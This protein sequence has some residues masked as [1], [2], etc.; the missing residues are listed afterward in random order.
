MINLF[1][2]F[3][4][5]SADLLRSQYIAKLKIPTV[6]MYDDGFLPKEVDSPIQYFC[7]FS[8]NHQ[9]LYFDKLPLPKYWRIMSTASKGEVFDLAQK[10]ADIIYSSGNNTRLI[11]EVHWLA[12]A[13]TISWVDHYNRH[14]ERFARTYY[15]QGE[16][17]QRKYYN[18]E[19][20]VVI[21]WNLQTN[22]LFLTTSHLQRHF[23]SL[24][25]FTVYY[26]RLRHYS[27]DHV[28]YNTLNQALAVSL[29]LPNNGE[30]VLFWHEKIDDKL[31]GNMQFLIDNST[32]TKHV[33]FQN[34]RDW[35]RQ[36]QFIPTETGDIDF[37]YLGMIFPHPRSNNLQ[38]NALILTNSDQIEQL[39]QLV[40]LLPNVHFN[41]ASITEMSG[42][43]LAY[44]DYP[45][46]SLY[47]VVSDQRLKQLM[48]NNDVYLDVN[49][50]SEILD[51]VRGAFEQNMLV[52]LVLLAVV[53]PVTLLAVRVV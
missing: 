35:Q 15:E 29:R 13:G 11:K 44:Q 53:R 39:A 8:N 14:G 46:V 10:R 41:V 36:K 17:V 27:L 45:N 47:P 51:A 7:K 33:I 21:D 32:R 25:D 42:K 30:D 38:P 1:E 12:P 23:A 22:D 9:P 18:N 34:Y 6:A 28:L 49:Y 48:A 20:Q 4:T 24:A 19:G 16:P 52:L 43:L 37:Q 50:G 3:D 5:V 40:K 31:P 26:L 2:H